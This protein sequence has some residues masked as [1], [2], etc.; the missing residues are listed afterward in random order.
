[1]I[2]SCYFLNL[3]LE[4]KLNKLIEEIHLLMSENRDLLANNE[5][6]CFILEKSKEEKNLNI[7]S[8]SDEITNIIS[9]TKGEIK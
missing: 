5:E 2:I 6:L 7:S 1:M 8:T 4:A 9:E 3:V